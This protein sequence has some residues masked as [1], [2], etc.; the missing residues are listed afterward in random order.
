MRLPQSYLIHLMRTV[1][2]IRLERLRDL[3]KEAGSIAN[4][5]RKANRNERD[6]TISQILNRWAG[7]SGKP[8]ELGS[9]MARELEA[10]MDKPRGW[11]DNEAL[12]EMRASWPFQNID[13]GQFERLNDRQKGEVEGRILAM[14]EK[15]QLGNSPVG[16]EWALK[17][18]IFQQEPIN[19]DT[20]MTK[21]GERSG[22]SSTGR[23]SRP[24]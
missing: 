11:M 13:P 9:D 1:E 21:T 4:L 3:V 24:K 5:N 14:L 15:P 20:N 17:D 22:G 23:R 10:A 6:A 8:K 18:D 12:H 7:K 19:S 16:G 2:E